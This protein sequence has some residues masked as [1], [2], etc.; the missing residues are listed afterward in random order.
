LSQCEITTTTTTTPVAHHERK[1][2]E[3]EFSM[4]EEERAQSARIFADNRQ[5][6]VIMRRALLDPKLDP[7]M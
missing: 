2:K 1:K 5:L 6:S 4:A 3:R 7:R